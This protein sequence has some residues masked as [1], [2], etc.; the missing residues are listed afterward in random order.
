MSTE[1]TNKSASKKKKEDKKPDIRK[2]FV[3]GHKNP[4]TDSIASAVAYAYLKNSMDES[5]SFIPM[6]A[7]HINQ[8]TEFVLKH[9]GVGEPDYI[10]N[11]EPQVKDIELKKISGVDE[12]ISLKKAYSIMKEKSTVTLPV[13]DEGD[14]LRGI[15]TINDIAESDMDVYDNCII[16]AAKT[17]VRNILETL[18]GE[19]VV[20]DE[21]FC[22]TKGKVVI[23]AANPD[24]M[25]NYIN[26]D[27]IV[28]LGNRYESQLCAIEMKAGCI[29]VCEG[30]VV[31]KTIRKIAGE[32]KCI[33]ITTPYDTY[34][35]ARLLNQ[36]MPISH[37]MCKE[38]LV[39]FETEESVE[40]AREVM[41]KRRFRDF[42]IVDV[43]GKYVGMISRRNLLNLHRKQLIL[44]DHNELGQAV[45]GAD[46]ADILEIIDHHRLGTIETS[47]PVYF[48]CQ[49]LGCTA[50][51]VKKLYAEAGVDIPSDMAGL[52]CSAI[53][54]DTL[55]F[56]SPTCTKEDMEAAY[57][58]AEKAGIKDLKAFAREMFNAGS[59]LKKKS[60]E[61]IF[62]QDFKKF[63]VSDI[64]FGVG[65]INSM[66][67]GDFP[68]IIEKLK[69]FMDRTLKDMKI[70]MLFFMLTGILNESSELICC[71]KDSASLAEEAF[72]VKAEND[73]LHLQGVV[74]RKKQL[75]PVI[76]AELQQQ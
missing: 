72:N 33:V 2:V 27:D 4:D 57:E 11:V 30:A 6:R 29:I 49:P 19:L 47:S 67:E 69:P 73:V 42:P 52:L 35:T 39:T 5:R 46:S 8:E 75:V 36:S 37:F 62:F 59:N 16:G 68:E 53:I 64:S 61:E 65:Q 70:D 55:M 3:V 25:E 24:V 32:N 10:S 28:I 22:I 9:F 23:A 34:T 1:K 26:E 56:R 41:A 18:E 20:G 14:R 12:G 74:S 38:N 21:K 15:I 51:I 40:E 31:S 7:G 60:A 13:V 43:H 71:G 48:R 63:N 76:V 58:L 50:T 66:N 17:P 44:I 54:S 45:D